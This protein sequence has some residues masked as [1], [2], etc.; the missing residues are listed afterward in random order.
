MS[1]S[2]CGILKNTEKSITKYLPESVISKFGIVSFGIVL[3][4]AFVSRLMKDIKQGREDDY[5]E[6]DEDYEE[7]EEPIERK[8]P[9]GKVR[10]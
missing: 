4:N 3:L 1:K 8:Q 10:F 2:E 9:I 6:D 7:I 5:Y